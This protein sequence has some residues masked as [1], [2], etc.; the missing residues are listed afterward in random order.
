MESESNHQRDPKD[1]MNPYTLLELGKKTI[2]EIISD[3]MRDYGI[4]LGARFSHAPNRG[5]TLSQTRPPTE[6]NVDHSCS[7]DS[8]SSGWD[9]EQDIDEQNMDDD[10]SNNSDRDNYYMRRVNCLDEE[11]FKKGVDTI[12]KW[13]G[14]W[15]KSKEAKQRSRMNSREFKLKKNK[16][17]NSS[18]DKINQEKYSGMDCDGDY[19]LV[20]PKLTRGWRK[21]Q[22]VRDGEDG[23]FPVATDATA[24][25]AATTESDYALSHV[26]EGIEPMED[27]NDALP[28]TSYDGKKVMA[29]VLQQM[30]RT[31]ASAIDLE[32]FD[33]NVSDKLQKE[34]VNGYRTLPR[35]SSRIENIQEDDK[36]TSDQSFGQVIAKMTKNLQISSESHHDILRHVSGDKSNTDEVKPS[37]QKSRSE[38]IDSSRA[39]DMASRVAVGPAGPT[40]PRRSGKRQISGNFPAPPP[41][42]IFASQTS[43]QISELGLDSVHESI[44]DTSKKV[45][46]GECNDTL[47]ILF[48]G[49][50]QTGKSSLVNAI[51]SDEIKGSRKRKTTSSKAVKV[52]IIEWKPASGRSYKYS[53]WDLHAG[54]IETGSHHVSITLSIPQSLCMVASFLNNIFPF[55]ST[56]ALFFS[57]NSL[58][59]V[60]WDLAAHNLQLS[61]LEDP[62]NLQADDI[63]SNSDSSEY[64]SDMD[65]PI[66]IE[67]RNAKR[68]RI[69]ERDIDD[70]V[71][72]WLNVIASYRTKGSAVLPVVTFADNV[73][74][75][76]VSRR[77]DILKR[78]LQRHSL[79]LKKSRRPRIIFDMNGQIPIVSSKNR[80]GIEDLRNTIVSLSTSHEVFDR[81]FHTI[82]SPVIKATRQVVQQL[83]KDGFEI[84][85]FEEFKIKVFENPPEVD[86]LNKSVL[87]EALEFLTSTGEILYFVHTTS[88]C[89]DPMLLSEF[90]VLNVSWLSNAMNYV[91]RKD[92][93]K[94]ITELRHLSY[95]SIDNRRLPGK[96]S[97]FQQYSSCPIVASDEIDSVWQDAEYLSGQ[98]ELAENCGHHNLFNFLHQVC[99][100][101]GIFVPIKLS[102]TKMYYLPSATKI[103]IPKDFW[104]FK[105]RN[106]WKTTLCHSF[107]ISQS[108]SISLMDEVAV[109][110]LEELSNLESYRDENMCVNQLICTK[111]SIYAMIEGEI[112]TDEGDRRRVQTEVFVS[113]VHSDSP[114][115]AGSDHLKCQ[116]RKLIVCGKGLEGLFG[117]R[118][119][120]MGFNDVLEA[121]EGTIKSHSHKAALRRIVC[122]QCLLDFP[123]AEAHVWMRDEIT[124]NVCGDEMVCSLGHRVH[125]ALLVGPNEDFDDSGSVATGGYSVHT[126]TSMLSIGTAQTSGTYATYATYDTTDQSPR[127]TV[128]EVSICHAIFL[129]ELRGEYLT[130]YFTID[131]AICCTC[132]VLGKGK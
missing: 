58:Y 55:Q 54:S 26:N 33:N 5:F 82:I 71:L 114:I 36:Y 73:P 96:R 70:N 1:K 51:S 113:L 10:E 4:K 18:K 115:C 94:T 37:E 19:S 116:E 100:H 14:R 68:D 9:G 42:C 29:P 121:V 35:I 2:T 102:E 53:L 120:N 85:H 89:S 43:N 23:C 108:L 98:Y 45:L 74:T 127:K 61:S 125:P 84:V 50:P 24:A 25:A 3:D 99:E 87:E 7:V 49:S 59:V 21:N 46:F 132:R 28:E 17:R 107:V 123:P 48:M 129:V 13:G 78:K 34:A 109:R 67:R 81:H 88:T 15:K 77:C 119:W 63:S 83:R 60:V 65:D 91:L 44:Q 72:H 32:S 122:P 79:F 93:Q 39:L 66:S 64:E 52:N 111:A 56:Q 103:D 110:V 76:E 90:I 95:D 16:Y 41:Q 69:I 131:H 97:C 38:S 47:K 31:A 86:I 128:E 92:F 118:I 27:D 104:S 130:I 62:N 40:T 112:R 6:I 101:I 80:D 117:D 126:S 22:P 12:G 8:A 124:L 105:V 20:K 106:S 57:T 30:N 11:K 75:N